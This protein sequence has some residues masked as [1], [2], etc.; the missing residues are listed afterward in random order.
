M[1]HQYDTA[2]ERGEGKGEKERT[3]DLKQNA[4]SCM[5]LMNTLKYVILDCVPAGC[6]HAFAGS[7]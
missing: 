1:T 3:I 7:G 2:Q 4:N 6:L 5:R